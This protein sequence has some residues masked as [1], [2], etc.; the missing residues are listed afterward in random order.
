MKAELP[1]NET[2][3]LRALH[4][5]AI[6]DSPRE[7]SFDDIAAV[8]RQVCDV[9]IAIVSLVDKER[10]WFKSCFGLDAIETPR[11]IA[12]CAHAILMP[13]DVLVVEDSTKDERFVDNVLVTGEPFIRFYAGAPLVTDDGMAMGTLCVIDC[14]PRKLTDDQLNA[15]KALSRQV[16]QLL[17]L[18][19]AHDLI[20][21]KEKLLSS[22]LKNFPGAAYRCK[23]DAKW[24]MVYLSHAV[25]QLTGYPAHEFLH[26]N[27]RSFADLMHPSDVMRINEVSEQAIA[28][29][30]SFQLEYRIQRADGEWRYVQEMGCGVFN[31][32]GQLEFIDGFIWDIQARIDNE[33]EKR[34]MA[35]KLAQLFETAPIGILQVQEGGRILATNPEF[36]KMIGYTEAELK[37]LTFIDITPEEDLWKANLALEAI[38][39]TG[40]FDAIEKVYRHKNGEYIPVEISGSLI[41]IHEGKGQTWW[42]LVKDIREQKRM[43][44]MKNE[45]ISTVSHELRT[46]LTSIS[47]ALGLIASNVLGAL[48]DKVKSMLDIAYKNSQRL[49]F[50]IDD[51]L[52]MEKLIAGKM[53]FDLHEQAVAP[54]IQQAIAENKSYA[55]KYTIHFIL[56]DA[57]PDA[58][59]FI[60]SFRFQQVLNNF[61]SNAAKYSPVQANV[62]IR[63]EEVNGRIRVSVVDY[64]QG[65]PEEF[66][67]RIFQKFSQAD[68]SNTREKGG[69]GLGLAIS[70]ELV[71]RMG[72]TIGFESEL[73]KGT[74]FYA[75]FAR[76][77]QD[78]PDAPLSRDNLP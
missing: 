51:L 77:K 21:Q 75:E 56:K 30:T 43:D 12:F 3:R 70:K 68:S 63:I 33:Y 65:I 64:G 7:Q 31:K 52:D 15:L 28:N 40:R 5:L 11:D 34:A 61:L 50:L 69:T 1:V 8:A 37:G 27:K 44:Q 4:D 57:A 38:K 39:T 14:K 74:C 13:D 47:G 25:E 53:V 46:P 6:L 29:K 2:L 20:Q 18:R 23:N 78:T 59:I 55:D 22:L 73:G 48:P 54:L 58:R 35:N 17:R 10:Q 60:D 16:V 49:S 72:G 36:N 66:K 71:E 32:Q 76:C 26:D 24:T 62:D 9:P 19:S 42:T 67:A 45:F 41:N